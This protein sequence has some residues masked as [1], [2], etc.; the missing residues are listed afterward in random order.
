MIK[1]R[2]AQGLSFTVIVVAALVLIVLVVILAVFTGNFG[3]FTKDIESC[4]LKGGNCKP[5][6]CAENEQTIDAT[7]PSKIE[8]CCV[9]F[10]D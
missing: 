4:A 3:K 6:Q 1:K 9:R 2:R 5:T 8:K 7:C 10:I